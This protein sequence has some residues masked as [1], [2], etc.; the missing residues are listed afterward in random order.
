MCKE[1]CLDLIKEKNYKGR[2]MR[3]LMDTDKVGKLDWDV[4]FLDLYGL[5]RVIHCVGAC[6]FPA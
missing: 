6:W 5:Q 4:P 2:M 1:L 3:P